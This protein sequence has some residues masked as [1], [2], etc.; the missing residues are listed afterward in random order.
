MKILS[1]ALVSFLF[2]F[3]SSTAVLAN[4]DARCDILS[5]KELAFTDWDATDSV[6]LTLSGEDCASAEVRLSIFADG[7]DKIF[8]HEVALIALTAV[9]YSDIN[10]RDA[11]NIV[12][13]AWE[14]LGPRSTKDLE[15]WQAPQDIYDLFDEIPA[16]A[17]EEY[18]EVRKSEKPY[19]C[20]QSYYEGA[21]CYWFA[22][23]NQVQLLLKLS[24]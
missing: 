22:P 11:L 9:N 21:D 15:P 2:T 18:E 19:I 20:V 13:R 24:N 7:A 17:C 23:Q 12:E 14:M 3:W 16:L 8:S 6:I 1:S 10:K 5:V 4:D